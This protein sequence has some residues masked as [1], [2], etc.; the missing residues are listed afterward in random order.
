MN[1]IDEAPFR[2]SHFWTNVMARVA[3]K[4]GATG[5]PQNLQDCPVLVIILNM[6]TRDRKTLHSEFKI[7]TLTAMPGV[8]LLYTVCFSHGRVHTQ[9]LLGLLQ[10]GHLT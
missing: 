1:F 5:C 4:G 3:T 8:H 9:S 2:S 6:S 10:V 7:Q